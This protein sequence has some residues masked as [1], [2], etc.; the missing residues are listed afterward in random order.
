MGNLQTPY[1]SE[2]ARLPLVHPTPYVTAN[3]TNQR[4][5]EPSAQMF[6]KVYTYNYG[7]S[8]FEHSLIL[9]QQS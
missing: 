7:S 3:L 8:A 1:Q 2:T 6:V 5:R 9:D 4:F